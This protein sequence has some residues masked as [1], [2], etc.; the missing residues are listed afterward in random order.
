MLKVILDFGTVRI[1]DWHIPL[2]LHAYGLMLVLGFLAALYY[3]RWRA[4]RAG[5][6][7]DRFSACGILALVGGIVGSRIAYVIQH[8]HGQFAGAPNR[9]T[10]V[11]DLTA[12]GLIY[13]GGVVLAIVLVVGYLVMRRLPVRRYLDILSVSLMIG[14]AF[15]RAGCLLNG[16]CFGAGCRRD[17][18]LG[19]TF[20][21]YS[22]PLI[23]FDGRDNPFSAS[24]DMLSPAYA[25]QLATG[26]IVP[27]YRLVDSDGLLLDPAEFT[28]EQIAIAESSRS[29]PVKPAQVLGMINALLIAGLLT[30][31][32]RLRRREGQVF[33]LMLMLY[34]VTRFILESIRDDNA[35]DLLA[36]VLTHNQYTSLVTFAVGGLMMLGLGKLPAVA[37]VSPA[38]VRAG[39]A[40]PSAAARRRSGT[41]KRK[42]R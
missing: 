31:F 22:K 12:G 33:A 13:Y 8:W 6:D 4:R 41:S 28:P 42:K 34:P 11:L 19:M 32:Y 2:R 18:P 26:Q 1:G 16:C 3:G 38:R 20:P 40:V 9:L 21:M 37:G 14:L 25:H 39:Q 7:D 15:G 5:E 29:L 35:H 17:W 27:D 23:K 10:A 30:G 36:G 24:R